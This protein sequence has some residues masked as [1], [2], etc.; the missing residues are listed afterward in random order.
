VRAIYYYHAI[1][2]DWGDIGYNFLIDAAGRVYE[3]RYSREYA[4]D[5]VPAGDDGRGHGVQAAHARNYNAGTL[6]IALIGD[7]EDGPP[8]VAARDALVRMLAW[9]SIRYGLNP[10]GF[11]T[12]VNPV[13]GLTIDSSTIAGHRDYNPTACPGGYLYAML[14]DVRN[15]VAAQIVAQTFAD[16]AGSPFIGDIA[17]LY[18]QTISNG[19]APGLFCPAATV[20][21]EQMASFL[22][23][24]LRLPAASRDYFSDDAGSVHEADINAVAEAKISLGCALDGLTYCPASPVTR[25]EMAS[26]LTRGLKLATTTVD[27]FVDDEDSLH[28][29][30]INRV[31][32]AGI[33]LGCDATQFCPAAPTTRGQM[34]A[35]LRRGLTR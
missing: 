30:A 7:F 24:A 32:Q 9:A 26:F 27:R 18:S 15:R 13:T 2:Q 35:F 17:W 8:T 16:V 23:R 31:A 12:Y 14:P 5:A 25:G 21:R 4:P 33:T 6:G 10:H 34:A 11:G 19:C 1:T 3:G 22:A 20:S 29:D 28:E